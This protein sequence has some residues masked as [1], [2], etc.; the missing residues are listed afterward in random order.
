[1][2]DDALTPAPSF[3]RLRSRFDLPVF[4]GGISL[5]L[6]GLLPKPPFSG[7]PGVGYFRKIRQ[8]NRVVIPP[9]SGSFMIGSQRIRPEVSSGI[10]YN[11]KN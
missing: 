10:L 11:D 7:V 5:L 8:Y 9:C 6:R 2:Y 4:S 1:L 3:D